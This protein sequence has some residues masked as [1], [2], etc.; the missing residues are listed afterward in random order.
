M[1][2]EHA[3]EIKNLYVKYKSIQS[4]SIRHDLLKFKS[5]E[6]KEIHALNDVSFEIEK[7]EVLGIVGQNGSGKSTLLRAI[8]GIFSPDQG[9]VDLH[10]NSVSLLAIGAGF[11]PDATGRENILL[12]GLLLGFTKQSIKEHE[13][14]IIDFSGLNDFIDMP[15]KTY[16]TGMRSKLAFSIAANLETDIILID[17]I[18]SVGDFKFRKKSFQKMKEI[19]SDNTRTAVI[20]SHQEITLRNLCDRILWLDQ[21]EVR[22]IGETKTVLDSYLEFMNS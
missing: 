15:V 17:E 1:E 11:N 3:A 9:S 4:Y 2:K 16:S 18:L 14:E 10:G 6:V 13:Q 21:G 19:I 8:A 22:M 7:G 12:N 20:V 5:S